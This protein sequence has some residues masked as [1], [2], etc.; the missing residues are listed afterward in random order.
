M[1]LPACFSAISRLIPLTDVSQVPDSPR[2]LCRAGGG[3]GPRPGKLFRAL[4]R[5]EAGAFAFLGLIGVFMEGAL[6]FIPCNTRQPFTSCLFFKRYANSW[7]VADC[8][9]AVERPCHP[10]HGRRDGRVNC[11]QIIL[12]GM[13]QAGASQFSGPQQLHRRSAG[14]DV[15][16]LLVGLHG[17]RYQRDPSMRRLDQCLRRHA[18][19]RRDYTLG[20]SAG[21]RAVFPAMPAPVWWGMAYTWGVGA[22][23]LAYVSGSAL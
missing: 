17:R 11:W 13:G 3:H 14:A 12:L 15:G 6:Q 19:G 22:S 2:V 8:R 10:A 21:H 1:W 7:Q 5:H 16:G 18:G 9:G 4:V 23:G 20:V